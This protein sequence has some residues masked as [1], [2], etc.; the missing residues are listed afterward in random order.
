MFM[1]PEEV[2]RAELQKVRYLEAQIGALKQQMDLLLRT[3]N[4]ISNTKSVLDSFTEEKDGFVSLGA[5][6]LVRAKIPA[7][8]VL[9]MDVGSGVLVEKQ[10]SE[11]KRELT[12]REQALKQ[13]LEKI[14]NVLTQLQQEYE[15]SVGVIQKL[16]QGGAIV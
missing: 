16:S 13:E 4:E 3:L 10:I 5:G 15:R 9:L 1:K 7:Q 2:L 12:K 6:V 8:D 11:V 14:R